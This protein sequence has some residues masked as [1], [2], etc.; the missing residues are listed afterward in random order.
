M[1]WTVLNKI[2]RFTPNLRSLFIEASFKAFS[3]PSGGGGNMLLPQLNSIDGVKCPGNLNLSSLSVRFVETNI[4][5]KLMTSKLLEAYGARLRKLS[6]THVTFDMIDKK[7]LEKLA[8]LKEFNLFWWRS[9]GGNQG[10]GGNNQ[11]ESVRNNVLNKLEGMKAPGLETLRVMLNNTGFETVREVAYLFKL[12]GRFPRL[13]VLNLSGMQL[14][15]GKGEEK[16]QG[17]EVLECLKLKDRREGGYD[18][19]GKLEGLQA[20]FIEGAEEYWLMEEKEEEGKG[21]EKED[22]RIIK[23][24]E[25][26]YGNQVFKSNIWEKIPRLRVIGVQCQLAPGGEEGR[27]LGGDGGV[28]EVE[29]TEEIC[30]REMYETGGGDEQDFF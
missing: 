20:L 25:Y 3:L 30:T 10:G 12:L 4:L 24:R 23:L 5:T 6:V 13:Q 14:E 18:F 22:K 8:N 16:M 1:F 15:E 11:L 29:E 21:E 27:E 9:L 7:S 2:L 26:L 17:N 28:D 19:L